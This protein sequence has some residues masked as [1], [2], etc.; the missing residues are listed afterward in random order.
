MATP[1]T[2]CISTKVTVE[3][4]ARYAHLAGAQ[5]VSGWV[6]DVLVATAS[7]GPSVDQIV[8]AEVVALRTIV[9]NLQFALA[10][11][12]PMTSETMH[13]LIARADED[14]VQAAAD[15]LAAARRGRP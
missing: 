13:R 5:T 11:G 2:K 15:R 10:S 6:R 4:Y 9:L 12:E 3:E 7:V 14:K 8:L 1:R